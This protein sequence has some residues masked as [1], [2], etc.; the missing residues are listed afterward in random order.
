MPSVPECF[1]IQL[2]YLNLKVVQEISDPIGEK[3]E[4]RRS[5]ANALPVGYLPRFYFQHLVVL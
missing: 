4:S 1:K 5:W 3:L 2:Y